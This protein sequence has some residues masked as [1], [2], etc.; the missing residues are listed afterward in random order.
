MEKE[1]RSTLGSLVYFVSCAEGMLCP[2]LYFKENMLVE[3]GKE[4]RPADQKWLN[5]L[6]DVH[7]KDTGVHRNVLRSQVQMV[8]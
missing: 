3:W 2:T 5:T 7:S 4:G 6:H 1:V 8:Y